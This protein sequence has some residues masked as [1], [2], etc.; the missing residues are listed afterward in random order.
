MQRR[1]FSSLLSVF[2]GAPRRART[3]LFAP[4]AEEV[5]G[6]WLLRIVGPRTFLSASTWAGLGAP[7]IR[8]EAP[9][10]E[11]GEESS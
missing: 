10:D 3:V 1:V 5:S 11:A 4:V 9:C 6:Y 7:P 2:F 8:A